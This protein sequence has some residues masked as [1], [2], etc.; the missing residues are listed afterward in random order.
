LEVISCASRNL[1]SR[2]ELWTFFTENHSLQL[3]EN[4]LRFTQR[5][6]Q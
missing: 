4:T 6:S 3:E 5:T 1:V 2:E